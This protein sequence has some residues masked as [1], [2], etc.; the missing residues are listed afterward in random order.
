MSLKLH[1]RLGAKAPS[2][3]VLVAASALAMLLGSMLPGKVVDRSAPASPRPP[4]LKNSSRLMLLANEPRG[5]SSKLDSCARSG[6]TRGF[7]LSLQ[8]RP[9]RKAFGY[10]GNPAASSRRPVGFA[11]PS[12]DGF[13][14]FGSL[15]F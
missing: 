1:G 8:P 6:L 13:A 15:A 3:T 9:G 12:R 2:A 14:F 10:T 5:Y 4:N 7:F 11:P